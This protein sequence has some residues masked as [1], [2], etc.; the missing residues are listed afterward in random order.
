MDQQTFDAIKQFYGLICLIITFIF[1][2]NSSHNYLERRE[3]PPFSRLLGIGILGWSAYIALFS[4]PYNP[5]DDWIIT[6]PLIYLALITHNEQDWNGSKDISMIYFLSGII[7]TISISIAN[8]GG[9]D[10]VGDI[11]DWPL[12]SMLF[13][14]F[15]VL[16]LLLLR[17]FILENEFV[18]WDISLLASIVILAYPILY[19]FGGSTV[20]DPNVYSGSQLDNLGIDYYLYSTILLSLS[21][22][23]KIYLTIFHDSKARAR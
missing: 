7:A 8:D 14:S 9:M 13:I 6:V 18:V 19:L 1:A 11:G 21:L 3:L 10:L 17:R 16:G 20:N 12:S 22:I 2:L 4:E 5:L 15:L 23:C